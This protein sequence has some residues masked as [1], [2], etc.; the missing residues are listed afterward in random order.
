MDRA[1]TMIV[2]TRITTTTTITPAMVNPMVQ[3]FMNRPLARS[4]G[5]GMALQA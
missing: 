2:T 1:G 3:P 4:A 5:S